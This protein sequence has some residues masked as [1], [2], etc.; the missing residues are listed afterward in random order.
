MI[1]FGVFVGSIV[2][3]AL[4]AGKTEEELLFQSGNAARSAPTFSVLPV[5]TKKAKSAE[6]ALTW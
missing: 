3:G 6:L 1:G 2:A 4:L 5:V